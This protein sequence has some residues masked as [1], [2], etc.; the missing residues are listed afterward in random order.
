ML[1]PVSRTS[2]YL[3]SFI[4]CAIMALSTGCA[5]GGFKYTRKYAQFINGQMILI[6]IIL[7]IF[8]SIVFVITMLVD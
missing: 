1:K 8:T 7:Y 6:R 4:A 2:F 5:S 3:G